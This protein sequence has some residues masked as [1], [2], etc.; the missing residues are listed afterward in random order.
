MRSSL[1]MTDTISILTIHCMVINIHFPKPHF[2]SVG[3]MRKVSSRNGC[4]L[5]RRNLLPLVSSTNQLL[6]GNNSSKSFLRL[7]VRA[8]L[9]IYYITHEHLK[10]L[11]MVVSPKKKRGYCYPLFTTPVY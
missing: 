11:V 4:L 6:K 1:D 7:T 9:N 5:L 10:A 8:Q 3:R 2:C